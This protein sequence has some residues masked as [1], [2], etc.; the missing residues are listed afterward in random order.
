MLHTLR[1]LSVCTRLYL[2]PTFSP[3]A[4]LLICLVFHPDSALTEVFQEIIAPK[5]GY[6]P[7]A[8]PP[9]RRHIYGMYMVHIPCPHSLRQLSSALQPP[10]KLHKM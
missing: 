7:V 9:L 10:L 2:L 1:R 8:P 6:I 5:D 4:A 3:I